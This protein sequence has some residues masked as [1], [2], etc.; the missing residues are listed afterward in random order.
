MIIIF[1]VVVF[2]LD[3]SPL[4]SKKLEDT[5]YLK[6]TSGR[7]KLHEHPVSPILQGSIVLTSFFNSDKIS[8][9]V[10]LPVQVVLELLDLP[11]T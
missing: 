7:F 11:N 9:L 6:V 8:T 4:L 3:R 10:S 5:V 2:L 1:T